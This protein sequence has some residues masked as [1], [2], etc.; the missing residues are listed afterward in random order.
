MNLS[1]KY[2]RTSKQIELI[3]ITI[4][5]F[6]TEPRPTPTTMIIDDVYDIG[7][8]VGDIIN[9]AIADIFDFEVCP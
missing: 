6:R 4:Y 1:T 9:R 2:I 8:K 7:F 5:R 3:H